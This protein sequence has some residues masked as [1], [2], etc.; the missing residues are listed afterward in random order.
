MLF[1]FGCSQRTAQQVTEL[2]DQPLRWLVGGYYLH[3]NRF[4]STTTG[5]DLGEGILPVY[6]TPYFSSATN[7]T[8]TFDADDNTNKSWAL[9]SSVS[10]DITGKLRDE[11]ARGLCEKRSHVDPVRSAAAEARKSRRVRTTALWQAA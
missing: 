4:I 1:A 8:L 5:E 6:E 7:P 9:F 3:T 10:Y 2:H 11:D